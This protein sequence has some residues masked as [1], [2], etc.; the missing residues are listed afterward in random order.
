MATMWKK[1]CKKICAFTDILNFSTGQSFEPSNLDLTGK[2]APQV[3]KSA[4]ETKLLI[5]VFKTFY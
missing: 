1:N 3:I 2:C 4:I 5:K